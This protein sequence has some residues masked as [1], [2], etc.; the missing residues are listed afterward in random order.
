MLRWV[1]LFVAAVS[2]FLPVVNAT[3]NSTTKPPV[4]QYARVARWLVHQ[5]SWGTLSTLSMHLEGA[6]YGHAQQ[7]LCLQSAS[8]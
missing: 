6:P 8:N 2:Y 5:A 3:S 7:T 4:E 1:V